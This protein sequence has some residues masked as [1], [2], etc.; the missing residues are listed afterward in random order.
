MKALV[1]VVASTAVV[2]QARAAWACGECL[3][4]GSSSSVLGWV[5]LGG[6]VLLVYRLMRTS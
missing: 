4:D 1:P 3:G 6:V 2:L 5:V